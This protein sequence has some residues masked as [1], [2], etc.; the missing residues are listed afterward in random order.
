M[1]EKITVKSCTEKVKN[2]KYTIYEIVDVNGKK[3]DINEL[4]KEG[5]VIECELIPDATGKG[6]NPKIK[7]IKSGGGNKSFVVKDTKRETALL[8]AVRFST[9]LKSGQVLELADKYY[10]WLTQK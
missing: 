2:D 4:S 8:C 1:A 6:Y 9:P 7:R 10:K 3:Y 5:D